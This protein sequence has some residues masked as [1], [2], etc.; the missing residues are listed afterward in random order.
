MKMRNITEVGGL[1]Q[2]RRT[3]LGLTQAQV[4]GR[5]GVSRDWVISIEKGRRLTVDFERLLRTLHVLG[6]TIEISAAEGH[7]SDADRAVLDRIS[8]AQFNDLTRL[9]NEIAHSP[10]LAELRERVA[11]L[12]DPKV[13]VSDETREALL[14]ALRAAQ[15]EIGDGK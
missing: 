5:A 12:I 15:P 11:E 2:Q 4:A 10:S 14:V 7:Q 13:T 3:D 9:R 1:I 8:R 6:L